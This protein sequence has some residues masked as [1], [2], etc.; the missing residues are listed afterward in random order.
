VFREQNVDVV[1]FY[2]ERTSRGP[3]IVPCTK[4]VEILVDSELSCAEVL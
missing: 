1:S 2:K 3:R 4:G